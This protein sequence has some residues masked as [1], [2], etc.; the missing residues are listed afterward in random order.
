[1]TTVWVTWPLCWHC[2]G[3]HPICDWLL[4]VPIGS[5]ASYP[6]LLISLSV[7]IPGTTCHM[8]WHTW[9]PG[10]R[11]EE[12]LQTLVELWAAFWTYSNITKTTP[13]RPLS[14]S[15]VHGCDWDHAHLHLVLPGMCQ[16]SRHPANVQ[17]HHCVRRILPGFSTVSTAGD[18]C[19]GEKA[20]VR[21]YV[22][23]SLLE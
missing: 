13:C 3:T 22:R 6:D 8:Q 20:W 17:V 7:L 15:V 10:G 4:A 18:K 12:W 1:M 9:M 23:T 2:G 5:V 11:L 14:C 16:S 21:M 19:W